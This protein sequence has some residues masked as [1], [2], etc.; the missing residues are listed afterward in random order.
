MLVSTVGARA[1]DARAGA[2]RTRRND[3]AR[4]FSD[5]VR[6]H[7][8]LKQQLSRWL[9]LSLDRLPGNERV[10]APQRIA[11][12]PG[13]ERPSR[14]DAPG[15]RPHQVPGRLHRRD[16]STR[17]G[18]GKLRVPSGREERG[19]PSTSGN[20]KRAPWKRLRRS[21]LAFVRNEKSCRAEPFLD[22]PCRG[23]SVR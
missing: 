7:H 23:G 18:E 14:Q 13:V 19:R 11:N 12:M 8:T 10:M 1:P 3:D 5:H 6:R 9:L 21:A 4:L 16:E 17:P 2:V 22:I 20:G 15:R